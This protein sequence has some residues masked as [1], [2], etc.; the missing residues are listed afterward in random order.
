MRL[1][2]MMII[3]LSIVE[4]AEAM[5][6]QWGCQGGACKRQRPPRKRGPSARKA[7]K[8]ETPAE[9]ANL[10]SS[11]EA[12]RKRNVERFDETASDAGSGISV[13]MEEA[14]S[15]PAKERYMG[16]EWAARRQ[17]INGMRLALNAALAKKTFKQNDVN[18]IYLNIRTLGLYHPGRK[19]GPKEYLDLLNFKLKKN[20]SGPSGAFVVKGEEMTPMLEAWNNL[21][22]KI[23]ANDGDLHGPMEAFWGDFRKV[24]KFK[25]F[26]GILQQFYKMNAAL[27]AEE[28]KMAKGEEPEEEAEYTG[29]GSAGQEERLVPESETGSEA[30]GG[31]AGEAIERGSLGE[32]AEEAGQAAAEAGQPVQSRSGQSVAPRSAE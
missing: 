17:A 8:T 13:G 18:E 32:P 10:A 27:R 20:P 9:K 22:N 28:A 19:P 7:K 3:G 23:V 11:L 4:Q 1:M 14:R 24:P 12:D 5:K 31:E 2:V 15:V 6:G 26:F 16:K 30:G 25:Y 21:L 29:G